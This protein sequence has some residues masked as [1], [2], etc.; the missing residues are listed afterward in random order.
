MKKTLIFLILIG[1]IFFFLLILPNDRE[2]PKKTIKDEVVKVDKFIIEYKNEI[3]ESKNEKYKIKNK[4]NEITIHNSAK[5]EVAK[6][7]ENH[8]NNFS[9][10]LFDEIKEYSDKEINK[11][12]TSHSK[13]LLIETINNT[14][15]YLS[16][17]LTESNDGK[18]REIFGLTYEVKVGTILYIKNITDKDSELEDI[19]IDEM[20]KELK[21]KVKLNEDWKN[22]LDEDLF[23]NFSMNKD[24]LTIYLHTDDISN[25]NDIAE[26][27]IDK[28]KINSLLKE[29][30]R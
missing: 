28:N 4:R 10:E 17:T 18:K 12:N 23:D 27:K 16:F 14:N 11:I 30:Y 20:E 8:L 22:Y 19:I 15:K 5:E 26:I 9:I 6:K 3:Y 2:K 1:I 25:K 21:R 24:Y 29:E 13:E 7:I